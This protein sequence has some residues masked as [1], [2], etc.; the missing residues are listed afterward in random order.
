MDD[1]STICRRVEAL[2]AGVYQGSVH[3]DVLEQFESSHSVLRCAVHA[4]GAAVQTPGTVIVKQRALDQP[5][6]AHDFDQNLLFRNEWASL[7][8][9]TSLPGGQGL[10]PRLVAS[11]R[12]TG[13][14]V[15]EDLGAVQSVQDVLYSP[16][17]QAVTAALMGMGRTLGRLQGITH[18]HEGEFVTLQN[19][20]AASTTVSD[21]SLD[22]RRHLDDL[23]ACLAGLDIDIDNNFDRAIHDLEGAIH[24]PGVF[25]TFVHNDAGPHNFVVTAS[26]VKLLDFEFAGYGHGLLDVV[27]AR[28]GFPPSFRGR[29][30]PPEIVRQLEECYRNELAKQTPQLMDDRI[31]SEALAQACAHWAFSKLIGFWDPYLRE[32]LV[33][34][35]ARDTRDSRAPKRSAF[36]R[37]QVFTYLRLT[38]GTLEEHDQLPELRLTLSRIIE[39]LLHI[40]PDTPYLSTYP[41]FGGDDWHYP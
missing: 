35:E 11:D 2:L 33:E 41:A 8:F 17:R 40:W 6:A 26:G 38:L 18:G 5:R 31:F 39:R 29:I 1:L 13:L 30:V 15:L 34:G 14:V 3:L 24:G 7:D 9:L 27:C 37:K 23:H 16:D 21:A 36:F 22:C 19:A 4:Q 20:L 10:G 32:R 25:H 12:L 28:L